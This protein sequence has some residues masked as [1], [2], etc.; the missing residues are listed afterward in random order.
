MFWEDLC[1]CEYLSIYRTSLITQ[2]NIFVL[3]YVAEYYLQN[4]QQKGWSQL[5][6]TCMSA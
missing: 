1:Y 5:N 2:L 4:N 3:S 6:K